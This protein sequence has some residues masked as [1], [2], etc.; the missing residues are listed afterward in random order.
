MGVLLAGCAVLVCAASG[1]RLA[2][3]WWAEHPRVTVPRAEGAALTLYEAA[4]LKASDLH[5]DH[6][7]RTLLSGMVLGGALRPDGSG[8]LRAAAGPRSVDALQAAVL[9][10]LKP[11]A[12]HLPSDL[13]ADAHGLDAVRAVERELDAAG[14]LT[15]SESETP[16]NVSIAVMA[17]TAAVGALTVIATR[18]PLAFGVFAALAAVGGAVALATP[19]RHDRASRRGRRLLAATGTE[20]GTLPA[21]APGMVLDE[22]SHAKLAR[23]A[24]YRVPAAGIHFG[25]P[26]YAGPGSGSGSGSGTGAYESG[27][28]PAVHEG[29]GLGGL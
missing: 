10:G 12:A 5:P 17:A 13:C 19:Q 16:L 27:G 15:R 11:G 23:M 28:G 20:T 2:F 29:P 9:A 4:A 24:L 25:P 6:L 14:L 3:R 7:P 22:A 26:S 21:R 8:R 1:Y 18:S